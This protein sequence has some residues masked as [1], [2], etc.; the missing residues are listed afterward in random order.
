MGM[1]IDSEIAMQKGKGL[2]G[3]NTNQMNEL[4]MSGEASIAYGLGASMPA[5]EYAL[6]QKFKSS[7]D[8]NTGLMITAT[9]PQNIK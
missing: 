2:V 4:L 1:A 6:S 7:I 9:M 8:T 3:V 5:Y